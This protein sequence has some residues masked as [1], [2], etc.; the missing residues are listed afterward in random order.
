MSTEEQ[1]N[2]ASQ[3]NAEENECINTDP[4]QMLTPQEQSTEKAEEFNDNKKP[5]DIST[6]ENEKADSSVV[7]DTTSTTSEV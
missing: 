5:E 7:L 1:S 3:F 6:L 2:S 4:S